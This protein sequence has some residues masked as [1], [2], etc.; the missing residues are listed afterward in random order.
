MDA[1][2]KSVQCD[3]KTL[4]PNPKH[5]RR[6]LNFVEKSPTEQ[7]ITLRDILDP[8]LV[9]IGRRLS[10]VRARRPQPAVV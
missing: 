10:P 5:D 3:W 9:R 1:Q 6:F 8:N 4:N 2:Q 7:L